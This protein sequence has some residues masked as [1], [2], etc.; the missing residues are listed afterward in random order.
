MIIP[1]F[2]YTVLHPKYLVKNVEVSKKVSGKNTRDKTQKQPTYK[3]NLIC[4]YVCISNHNLIA[5]T[6]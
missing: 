1:S 3:K 2:I 5:L 4:N 6:K